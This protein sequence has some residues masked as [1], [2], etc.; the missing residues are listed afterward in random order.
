M[1]RPAMSK[2]G[3]NAIETAVVAWTSAPVSAVMT[4]WKTARL[5]TMNANSPEGPRSSAVST[6]T[7]HGNL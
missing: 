7:F 6:E 1:R 5:A 4:L 3:I 2:S